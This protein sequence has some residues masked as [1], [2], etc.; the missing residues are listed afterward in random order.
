MTNEEAKARVKALVEAYELEYRETA[1]LIKPKDY[2][3]FKV[4]IKALEARLKKG[5]WIN[6]N[7]DYYDT[8]YPN[9]YYCSNCK[10]Y[11][12]QEPYNLRYCPRCGAKMKYKKE[13]RR[14]WRGHWKG[15]DADDE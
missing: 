6:E 11:Y 10:D 8:Y 3:A 5:E 9:A 7:P 2:E 14:V 4:A 13:P 1:M 15:G 12:T